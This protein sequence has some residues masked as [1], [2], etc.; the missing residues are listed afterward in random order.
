VQGIDSQLIEEI[1]ASPR[2]YGFHA[3][4]KPPF[5]L[6]QREQL[7]ELIESIKVFA[8]QHQVFEMP[9]LVL[10]DLSGFLALRPEN[11]CHELIEFASECVTYFDPFRRPPT[12]REH[13]KRRRP[14]MLPTQLAMLERWGYP[15]VMDEFRFHMTLTENI[16]AGLRDHLCLALKE[17]AS[18]VSDLPLEMDAVSLFYQPGKN[19]PFRIIQRFPLGREARK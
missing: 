2:H 15:Y 8:S 1:T 17:Q 11:S 13:N 6:K 9:K 12:E 10:T 7:E 5:H 14:G 16:G 3:T 4:L 18:A 19:E